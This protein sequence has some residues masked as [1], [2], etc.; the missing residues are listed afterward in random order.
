MLAARHFAEKDH[1][2]RLTTTCAIC[3]FAAAAMIGPGL[4]PA[5]AASSDYFLKLGPVKGEGSAT[6]KGHQEQIEILSYSFGASRKGWDG[7]V[8]G[9]SVAAE[10]K[11]WDG[12]VK[13][14]TTAKFG[15]IAGAHRNDGLA[16]GKVSVQDISA[17]SMTSGPPK[18]SPLTSGR[19]GD[20]SA[21]ADV[22]ADEQG[23]KIAQPKA[24]SHDLRTN[25]VAR[26]AAPPATGSV[27]VDGNF[28]GC[29]VGTQY[30]DA[31]LQLAGV[32]YDLT[33]VQITSCPAP[34]P[35]TRSS[36]AGEYLRESLSLNYKKVTVR[37]WNPETKEE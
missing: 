21:A 9:G 5:I 16:A 13:G 17:P 20:T 12:S 35:A 37:G 34:V 3:A 32:R 18:S 6:K 29:T 24:V 15:A 11:G 14:N 33:D 26:T 2:M 36:M 1:A 25:V 28:P 27:T 30:A 8:K 22:G 23:A 19:V 10:R 31:V 7:T 4:A